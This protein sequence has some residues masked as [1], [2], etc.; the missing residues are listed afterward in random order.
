MSDWAMVM[1]RLDAVVLLPSAADA[2]VTSRTFRLLSRSE[3]R[4]LVRRVL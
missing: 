4:R 2:L 3:N 1:A